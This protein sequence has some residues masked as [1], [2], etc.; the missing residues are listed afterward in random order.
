MFSMWSGGLREFL[1]VLRTIPGYQTV[2]RLRGPGLG[3]FSFLYRVWGGHVRGYQ[4]ESAGGIAG[5]IG[6][7]PIPGPT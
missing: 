6:A 4:G 2:L 5:G 7:G 3:E 1:C